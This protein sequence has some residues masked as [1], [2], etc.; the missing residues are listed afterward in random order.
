[1]T[2]PVKPALERSARASADADA[3][4]P[5]LTELFPEEGRRIVD[6]V[7]SDQAPVLLAATRGIGSLRGALRTN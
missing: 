4:R 7:Q 3:K 5:F 6:G 2:E 1:M